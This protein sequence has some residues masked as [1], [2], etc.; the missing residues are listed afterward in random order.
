MR[1]HVLVKVEFVQ[2]GHNLVTSLLLAVHRWR[3]AVDH[4]RGSLVFRSL[5]CLCVAPTVLVTRSG[6]FLTGGFFFG[7]VIF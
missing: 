2:G 6:G 3:R 5:C 4:T 1:R 7:G